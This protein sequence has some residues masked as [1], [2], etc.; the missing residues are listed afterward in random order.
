[1]KCIILVIGEFCVERKTVRNQSNI[2]FTFRP[3]I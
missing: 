2:R 3:R 1:M